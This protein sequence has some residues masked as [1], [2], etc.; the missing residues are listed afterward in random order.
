M[1]TKIHSNNTGL[2]DITANQAFADYALMG[3]DMPPGIYHVHIFTAKGG[4]FTPYVIWCSDSP[5]TLGMNRHPVTLVI[6]IEPVGPLSLQDAPPSHRIQHC[7][8]EV[9]PLRPNQER[10]Q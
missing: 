1:K 7:E 5:N 10:E 3:P 6:E 2:S 9:Q 4:S 8:D